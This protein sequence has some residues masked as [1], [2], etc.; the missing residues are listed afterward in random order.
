[1]THSDYPSN[2]GKIVSVVA[3]VGEHFGAPHW[4]VKCAG[5][6]QAWSSI[7]GRDVVTQEMYVPDAH[8]RP[9]GGVPVHDEIRDEVPA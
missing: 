8:L 2:I 3:F 5:P 9:I 4:D 6:L 7:T 1:M